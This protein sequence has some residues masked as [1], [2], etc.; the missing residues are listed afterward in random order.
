MNIIKATIATAAVVTCCLGNTYPASAELSRNQANAF[1]AGHATGY[2]LGLVAGGC[3]SYADG[4]ISRSQ[5]RQ[6]IGIAS[7]L[8]QTNQAMRDYIVESMR[9][10]S[11]AHLSTYQQCVPVVMQVM[12]RSRSPY[13]SADNWR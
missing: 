12:G 6:I 10:N 4:S 9:D 5:Y 13:Q 11:E 1:R 8:K 2:A 3:V 7:R